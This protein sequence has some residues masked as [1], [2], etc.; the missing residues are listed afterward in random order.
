MPGHQG[1]C[2]RHLLPSSHALQ[3][4]ARKDPLYP[5]APTHAPSP[6]A[7]LAAQ[8]N[9]HAPNPV[10]VW[11]FRSEYASDDRV[12]R[13][14]RISTPFGACHENPGHY[15]CFQQQP[16][17]NTSYGM[18]E[19]STNREA[20]ILGMQGDYHAAAESWMLVHRICHPSP[21]P[22]HIHPLLEHEGCQDLVIHL[23]SEMPSQRCQRLCFHI[24]RFPCIIAS[25]RCRSHCQGALGR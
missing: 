16:L 3:S 1:Y 2:H 5:L 10:H 7:G 8:T 14:A 22:I 11:T 6:Q 15:Y 24:S 17:F 21:D 19:I 25:F 23:C 9:K 20:A 18:S 12:T 4:R 13:N